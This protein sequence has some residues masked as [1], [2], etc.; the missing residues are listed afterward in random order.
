MRF[1][2][3]RGE[4][5]FD[6][7]NV[8][9]LAL[10]GLLALYPFLYIVLLSFS[11]AA[12]VAR[13]G[14]LVLPRD[15]SLGSYDMILHD[16]WFLRGFANSLFRTVLGV[17]ATLL[18]TALAAY[19]LSRPNLPWR[20][21]IVF[22]ILFTMLFSGGLVPKYLLLRNLG[23]IDNRLVLVL[24][25]MLTCFQPNRMFLRSAW[26]TSRFP[27]LHIYVSRHWWD[28]WRSMRSFPNNYFPS[29]F[30]LIATLNS[31]HPL[32]RPLIEGKTLPLAETLMYTGEETPLAPWIADR[33]EVFRFYY[34]IYVCASV[35]SSANA[36]ALV[37]LSEGEDAPA[38]WAA[39]KGQLAI[40]GVTADFSDCRMPA[41]ERDAEFVAFE[42][43]A[44][45]VEA[46]IL[47]KLPAVRIPDS[48]IPAYLPNSSPLKQLLIRFR[49]S[50]A[51]STA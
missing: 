11:T 30:Y 28:I 44:A 22:Y 4:I 31:G 48:R 42:T 41:Y 24:P 36:D 14:L 43:V 35:L 2:R 40:E 39:L 10:V 33:E 5:A 21:Q 6:W 26:F 47:E 17:A 1:K 49:G 20:R 8:S 45:E 12:D 38:M 7:L 3:S 23:L 18:M 34:Y 37:D 15:F 29:R 25:L 13:G 27:S 51:S 9:L 50:P 46:L 32:I 16:P 19:P